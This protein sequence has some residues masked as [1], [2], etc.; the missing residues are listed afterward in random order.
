MAITWQIPSGQ[1]ASVLNN[2]LPEIASVIDVAKN[3]LIE[4]I[5]F[6]T[7]TGLNYWV[8]NLKKGGTEYGYTW[9]VCDGKEIVNKD[10][11][12]LGNIPTQTVYSSELLN[13]STCEYYPLG[14][15]WVDYP[16][17]IQHFV[18]KFNYNF[19]DNTEFSLQIVYYFNS[20]SGSSSKYIY[21]RCNNGT[22]ELHFGDINWSSD[23]AA[24]T[25]S[26][27][28]DTNLDITITSDGIEYV[29]GTGG[30][31]WI[32]YLYCGNCL[33]YGSNHQDSPFSSMTEYKNSI[34]IY[35]AVET[36][37]GNFEDGKYVETSAITSAV[38]SASTDSEIPTAKAV[39]NV[40]SQGGGGGG[41]TYSAGTNID[42][43]NDT[44]NCTLPI[45]TN[46]WNSLTFNSSRNPLQV[47]YASAF[48]DYT[49]AS[50]KGSF[51]I[52]KD[53]TAS[54]DYSFVGGYNYSQAK[55]SESFSFGDGTVA[56]KNASVAFGRNITTNN[57]CE[58]S[59]GKL[60]KSVSASTT[61]GNSG[62]TLFSVG[63]GISSYHNAFEIRQNGDI[64]FNDGTN[65]VKLQ[66]K[67]TSIETTIGDI[68]TIL[69]SI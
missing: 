32:S 22:I 63:N 1:T 8:Y 60:N 37:F 46:A 10:G 53:T 40:A 30:T 57:E 33:Y 11:L 62:N 3:T 68:N 18:L 52:G 27:Q 25:S 20:G 41:T 17:A 64:Y 26:I 34:G 28:N 6:T 29:K 65:D 14:P 39:W 44:I 35:D 61:F 23:Y 5:N 9:Q 16:N 36:L 47:L 51:S 15:N 55:G 2:A 66:D 56:N 7:N 31:E 24:L 54:G 67:F 59:C 13:V 21:G 4:N 43:T 69:Q 12:K 58:F 50:G 42:I 19:Y 49:T 38:T 48:G 45:K